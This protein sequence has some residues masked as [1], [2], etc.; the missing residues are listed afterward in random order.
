MFWEK[1]INEAIGATTPQP[2]PQPEPAPQPQATPI[3]N[4]VH[5]F[6]V[7]LDSVGNSNG[8]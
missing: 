3:E 6:N 4:S 5:N 2:A 7:I 8:K 1:E